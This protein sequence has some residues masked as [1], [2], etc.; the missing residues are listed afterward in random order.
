[1]ED[2]RALKDTLVRGSDGINHMKREIKIVTDLIIG[3]L[4]PED[5]VCSIPVCS[6]LWYYND[7][8]KKYRGSVWYDSTTNGQWEIDLRGKGTVKFFGHNRRAFN[9]LPDSE[10]LYSSAEG[11]RLEHVETV[12][13]AL[14][15]FLQ[16]I[17]ECVPYMR[18][19][20]APY[21]QAANLM[22]T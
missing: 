1:M 3:L 13:T 19:R 20:I 2:F 17:F 6:G 14:P 4:R 10:L 21:N 11:M 16:A 5:F 8:D 9:E 12:Y 15:A 18:N 22:D 7:H